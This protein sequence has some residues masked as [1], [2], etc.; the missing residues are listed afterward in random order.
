MKLRGHKVELSNIRCAVLNVS[1]KG[2]YVVPRSQIEAT[3]QLWEPSE[4]RGEGD[5]PA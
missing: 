5:L 2:D 1:D 3:I 4:Q